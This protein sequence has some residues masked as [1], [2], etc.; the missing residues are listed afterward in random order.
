MHH[1]VAILAVLALAVGIG[2]AVNGPG[3]ENACATSYIDAVTWRDHL[4]VGVDL[5]DGVRTGRRLGTGTKAGD[6]G[7]S[8]LAVHAVG[9]VSP[10]VAVAGPP[11]PARSLYLAEGFPVRVREHPLHRAVYRNGPERTGPCGA[12]TSFLGVVTSP[13]AL[14]QDFRVRT[15]DD[16]ERDVTLRASASIPDHR[17]EGLPYLRQGDSVV[18]AARRC[19]GDGGASRLHATSIRRPVPP[20]RR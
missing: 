12:R 19:A 20:Y 17:R 9:G 15:R 10:P 18:V 7:G 16:G 4:Y 2:L 11:G 3:T 13:P 14:G 8:P 5:P 1:L 6:C